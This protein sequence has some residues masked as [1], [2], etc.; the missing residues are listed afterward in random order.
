MIIDNR[1]VSSTNQNNESS[2]S[3]MIIKLNF[4]NILKYGN[5]IF[6]NLAGNEHPDNTKKNLFK[7][8]TSIN[9][10]LL[11]LKMLFS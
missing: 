9:Y 10:S 5:L 6:I 2:R 4:E 11:K 3:H 1:K 8:G 7:E